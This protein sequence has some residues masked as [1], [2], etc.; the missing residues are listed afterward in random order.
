[1]RM[2]V[3]LHTWTRT[4]E[5]RRFPVE[6]LT[7]HE[8]QRLLRACDSATPAGLRNRALI[9]VLYRAGLRITEALRLEPKDIGLDGAIR[10]L[11]AKGGRSRTVGMDGDPPLENHS[12]RSPMRRAS[13][14]IAPAASG[15]SF[16]KRS[17]SPACGRANWHR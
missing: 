13:D 11:H 3:T 10:V 1:M 5:R 4:T 15:R 8:I 14:S 9:A 16:T 7:E 17:C 12:P 2:M 6:I